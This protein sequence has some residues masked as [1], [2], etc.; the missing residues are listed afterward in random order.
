MLLKE[1]REENT[2]KRKTDA[3]GSLCLVHLGFLFQVFFF[4]GTP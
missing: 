2:E 4:R 3:N 1:M